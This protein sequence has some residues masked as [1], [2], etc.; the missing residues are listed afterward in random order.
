VTARSAAHRLATARRWA[1]G[2]LGCARPCPICGRHARLTGAS[3]RHAYLRCTSCGLIY[4]SELPAAAEVYA[5]YGAVH[6]GTYQV[7][8]KLNW[9][10]W[11][12]HK[13]RTL[14]ALELPL[15]ERSLGGR[16]GRALEVGCGEGQ[17]LA[18]LRERGWDAS[19]IELNASLSEQARRL[20]FLVATAALEEATPSG[21]F[22]LVLMVHLIEHLR[23]PLAALERIRGSLRTEGWL[24]VETPLRPDLDNID[25]LYCFSAAALDLAL[26]R[27]RFVPRRWFDY[28]DDHYRHHN[29]AVAAVA[30]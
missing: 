20:G 2:L 13:Q 15:L 23:H 1:R 14:E 18:V 21:P 7:E 19:G 25:H 8:H 26:R 28:V 12:A 3:W 16:A 17:L 29:L 11:R 27:S 6:R 30:T 22:D 4:V 9:S 10:A 5:S 24:L